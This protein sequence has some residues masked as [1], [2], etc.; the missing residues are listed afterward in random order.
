MTVLEY[1]EKI[2]SIS[3]ELALAGSVVPNTNLILHVLNGVG[4][5]YK[6]IV[7]AV[8]AYD[9]PI[10]LEELHDKLIEYK[11]FLA[12]EVAKHTNGFTANVAQFNRNKSS[13]SDTAIGPMINTHTFNS[14]NIQ[15]NNHMEILS[16]AVATQFVEDQFPSLP[17]QTKDTSVT[18]HTLP[19][20]SILSLSLHSFANSNAPVTNIS[21][22]LP[23]SVA[24]NFLATDQSDST[25][26]QNHRT[27]SSAHS[28]QTSPPSSSSKTTSHSFPNSFMASQPRQYPSYDHSLQKPSFQTNLKNKLQINVLRQ[29]K[30]WE[31][32]P[33]MSNQNVVG[34]KW[35]YRV[36]HHPDGSVARYKARLVA[37]GFHQQLGIDYFET[38]SPVIKPN[39]IR[40][41]LTLALSQGWPI[42]QLDVNNAFLHNH[43]SEEV[44]MSQPPGFVD[45]TYPK[46]VCRLHRSIYDLKQA[47]RA[48]FEELKRFVLSFGFT[49]ATSDTS[50]F[51]YTHG[52]SIM[53]F[54][55]Y[56]DDLFITGSSSVLVR[57][58][59]DTLSGQ[60]LVKDL[61]YLH[62]F[63][64][65]KSATPLSSSSSLVLKD[66]TSATDATQHRKLIG[67]MQYLSISQPD[68]AYAHSISHGLFLNHSSSNH[69]TAYCDVNWAGNRDD[70]TSTSAFIIFL[71]FN[72][73]SWCSK[74]QRTI[75]RS[76]TKAEYRSIASTTTEIMWLRNL[77][78]ELQVSL[79]RPPQLLCDN[80]GAT[81]LC[82]NPVFHSR[83]K[84]IALNYHFVREQVSTG[85]LQVAHVS[86]IHQLAVLLTKP[87]HKTRFQL[88]RNKIG[89]SDDATILR[90]HNR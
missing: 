20:W 89:V 36:K 50:L 38:F 79:F 61:G 7:V 8:R 26:L 57:K 63:L 13:H 51:V 83:M 64:G 44:F 10:N 85:Q 72:P 17:S 56:V 27:I 34:C 70:F 33:R 4:S 87:L 84:H 77:L 2:H 1:I 81:Y 42:H 68:I 22:S 69:F 66:G 78:H 9:T 59:I 80:L 74:K 73:V 82:A 37:K 19:I 18:S 45:T 24:T 35:V 32:V 30:T 3:D 48:W 67:S 46:H 29:H 5:E 15:T 11:S 88:L 62:H 14:T 71:G 40:V 6:K 60:F 49:N 75:A 28:P 76:S 53:Y 65:V 58:F 23:S 21:S 54:L 47:S 25:S 39:T 31:L 43:L 12:R 86:T 55:V 16:K 90:G 41:M 52:D